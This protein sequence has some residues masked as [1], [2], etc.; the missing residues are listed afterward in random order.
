MKQTKYQ[1]GMMV[2][3]SYKEA[4]AYC[5]FMFNITGTMLAIVEIK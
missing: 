3:K 1:V 4:V 5:S 2:C